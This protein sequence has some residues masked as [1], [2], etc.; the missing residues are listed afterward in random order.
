[1]CDKDTYLLP[2]AAQEVRG[3]DTNESVI[4]T[5]L[6][7]GVSTVKKSSLPRTAILTRQLA[8]LARHNHCFVDINW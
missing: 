2:R 1:M 6:L 5:Y 8:G 7:P 3:C 4:Q